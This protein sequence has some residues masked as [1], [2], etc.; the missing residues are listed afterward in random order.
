MKSGYG[1]D[2]ETELKM[3]RVARAV[4]RV[5]PV[6]VKTT[7][8]GAHAGGLVNAVDGFCEGIAF[9]PEQLEPVFRAARAL[10]LPVKLHAEQLSNIGGTQVAARWPRRV[11][12]R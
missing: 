4:E 5:R 12:W 3:L 6:W 8:L 11:A 9:S 2:I 10:G 7:F 1:L